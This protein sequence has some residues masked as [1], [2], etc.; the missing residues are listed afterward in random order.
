MNEVSNDVPPETPAQPSKPRPVSD[1]INDVSI[2]QPFVWLGKGWA[3]FVRA[4]RLSIIYGLIYT[5]IG[6]FLAID[7][8]MMGMD[9]LIY[10]LTAGFIL[11]GPVLAI[12]MY[13]VSRRIER[14]HKPRPLRCFM[15]WK[16]N[17]YHIMTAGLVFMIFAIAWSRI[18]V[19]SFVLTFPYIGLNV[20]A[21]INKVL[22]TPEGIIFMIVGTMMGAVLAAIAFVFGVVALPMMLDRKVDI[23]TA[24]LVSFLVV[25]KN[26]GAMLT[27]GGLIVIFIGAGLATAY[28]GL[29]VTLPL[30][31]YASWHAY[32]ACVD[33]SKW[34][35]TPLD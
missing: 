2:E 1:Y 35:E 11:G 30:I 12:G 24:S 33:P 25:M 19:L 21:I 6:V 3:D 23:F 16:N 14:G 34:P 10:P 9:Y 7:L 17:R 15:A 32:R 27:W 18:A 29:A 31:A 5:V 26:K 4:P 8:H 20:E 22:F 13:N 28:I